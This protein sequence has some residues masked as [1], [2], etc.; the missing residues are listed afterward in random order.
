[1]INKIGN[2]YSAVIKKFGVI[3]PAILVTVAF[4]CLLCI[5][6]FDGL[7]AILLASKG[8]FIAVAAI[9]GCALIAGVVYSLNKMKS[10]ELA[11]RDLLLVCFSALCI[12]TLIMF[13]FTGG[14]ISL[15]LIKWVVTLILF[16]VSLA[17]TA[18]RAG[19]VD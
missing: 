11:L 8:V 4:L 1:M 16:V 7:R 18:V 19:N 5:D 10:K 14:L 17:L 15:P 13:I 6:L 3:I 9:G 2:Y 12:P